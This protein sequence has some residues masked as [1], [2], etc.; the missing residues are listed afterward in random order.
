[1]YNE[2]WILMYMKM[3]MSFVCILWDNRKS[4]TENDVGN[5]KYQEI[6]NLNVV[7]MECVKIISVLGASA[8]TGSDTQSPGPS[9]QC[10]MILSEDEIGTFQRLD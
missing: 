6:W 3:Y 1:M 10:C 4:L 2:L 5:R 9:S 8:L 7:L